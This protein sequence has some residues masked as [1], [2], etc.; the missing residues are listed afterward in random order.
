ML[1]IIFLK[2]VKVSPDPKMIKCLT[3]DNLL[4]LGPRI[5][6]SVLLSR[7]SDRF[8]VSGTALALFESYLKSR[9]YYVQVEGSKSI[10]ES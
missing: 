6:D 9:K 1:F 5:V 7:L 3:F 8:G 2:E 10:T 4:Q